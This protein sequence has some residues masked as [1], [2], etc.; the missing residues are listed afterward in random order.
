MHYEFGAKGSDT[1]AQS[2]QIK[3]KFSCTSFSPLS[4][5]LL[6][7]FSLSLLNLA[8]FPFYV[9]NLSFLRVFNIYILVIKSARSRLL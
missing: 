9:A 1:W 3:C 6:F 8:G 4:L 7:S 5:F 2:E